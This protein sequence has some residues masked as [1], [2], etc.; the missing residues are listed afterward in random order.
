MYEEYMR[1]GKVVLWWVVL[2]FEHALP[3]GATATHTL[4]HAHGHTTV[5]PA[6]DLHR[7]LITVIACAFGV[8]SMC[9]NK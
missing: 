8:A 4:S 7:R 3:F 9:I 2:L 6:E 5:C 1:C